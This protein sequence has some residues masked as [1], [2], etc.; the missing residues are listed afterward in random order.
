M[1]SI[2]PKNAVEHLSHSATRSSSKALFTRVRR[3]VILRTSHVGAFC[4]LRL[5]GVLRSSHRPLEGGIMLQG[6]KVGPLGRGSERRH[7]VY[8]RVSILEGPR[9]SWTRG[10]VRPGRWSCPGPS[11]WTD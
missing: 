7:A 10:F 5:D 1:V 6:G 9:S 3:R 11:R 8:A 4:E 2:M